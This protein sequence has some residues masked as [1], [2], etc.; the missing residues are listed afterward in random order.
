[1]FRRVLCCLVA[2][3]GLL[4][5]ALPALAQSAPNCSYAAGFLSFYNEIPNVIGPCIAD[6]HVNPDGVTV[7]QTANGMLG[8][9]WRTQFT[10]G[11]RTWDKGAYLGGSCYVVRVRLNTQRFPD[12]ESAGFPVTDGT[13]VSTCK[14]D[15]STFAPA[16]PS[17]AVQTP[18][19]PPQVSSC[20]IWSPYSNA[21]L[22]LTG[23]N[24]APECTHVLQVAGRQ[25]PDSIGSNSY[26]IAAGGTVGSEPVDCQGSLFGFGYVV[27]DTGFQFQGNALCNAIRSVSFGS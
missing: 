9:K 23:V 27:L 3:V 16:S 20:T 4:L 22:T 26:Q 24:P 19:A 17:S 18:P 25:A 8:W 2:L 6:E 13:V 12:E 1:M 15:P 5:P 10:D 7:Q 21:L 11:Y 14:G